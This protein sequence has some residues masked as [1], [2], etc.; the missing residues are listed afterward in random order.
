[1][2]T[3]KQVSVRT[4]LGAL[5]RGSIPPLSTNFTFKFKH[6]TQELEKAIS[7]VMKYHP[8]LSIIVFDKI[9]RW[10][11]MDD[12]F[13]Y[14]KFDDRIDQAVLEEAADSIS[15]FPFIYQIEDK[16][17]FQ[18]SLLREQIKKQ[19]E[20]L[21]YDDSR[22]ISRVGLQPDFNVSHIIGDLTDFVLALLDAT[23]EKRTKVLNK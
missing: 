6:M 10:L 20:P 3:R 12:E 11:Y 16:K 1:M 5:T 22:G 18:K 21:V 9:G 8:N 23:P 2:L 19:L 15:T 14:F 4:L 13:K 7:E 17:R